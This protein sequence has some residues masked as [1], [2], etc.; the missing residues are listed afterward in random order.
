MWARVRAAAG[1]PPAG[2]VGAAA[3]AV[4]VIVRKGEMDWY[5]DWPRTLVGLTLGA[6]CLLYYLLDAAKVLHYY[7]CYC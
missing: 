1:A 2:G 3:A 5:T 6:G 7:Y 4:S